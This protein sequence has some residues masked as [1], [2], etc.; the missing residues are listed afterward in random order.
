M[1]TRFRRWLK[2]ASVALA[3]ACA[4]GLAVPQVTFAGPGSETPDAQCGDCRGGKGS[5]KR[6]KGQCGW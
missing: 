4:L 3:L 6:C 2:S 1:H 5:G